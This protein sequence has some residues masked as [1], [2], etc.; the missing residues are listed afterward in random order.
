MS[1]RPRQP[2]RETKQGTARAKPRAAAVLASNADSILYLPDDAPVP[3]ARPEQAEAEAEA[4]VTVDVSGDEVA[5]QTEAIVYLGDD[6]PVP[7]DSPAEVLAASADAILYLPDEVP[8]VPEAPADPRLYLARPT[9]DPSISADDLHYLAEGTHLRLYEKLG[10][11]LLAEGGVQFAVWAPNA[12]HVSVIGEW[13]DWDPF[14]HPL[15]RGG[16]GLWIGRVAEAAVGMLYKYRVIG[17]RGEVLDKADPCALATELPPHTASR[18]ADLEYAWRDDAWLRERA[19]RQG[20]HAPIS[21]YELHLGSWL[22][23][24]EGAWL[25]YREIAA[26]LVAHVRALGFTHVEFMPL[27]EHPFYGSWG[28]QTSGYFAPS[29]R[30]GGPQA[31]M[32]LIDE[33]HRAEIGVI[34]DWVPGHFPG[35]AHGLHRFDGTYLYE[36]RDPSRGVHPDW[37]TLIFNHGRHEVRA[38]LLS[39]ASMWIERYHVDAIRVDAVASMLY[40]DYSRQPGQWQPNAHGG[41]ENLEAVAF[42]RALNQTIH[43]RHPGVITIAE[44]STAWPLVTGP[45]ERGGLGFDLKWDMGWMHDSLR[46]LGR[47]PV[48]RAQHHNELTFRMWY[49]YNERYMLPLSHDEVVHGK[50][51]LIRKMYGDTPAK[52]AGLRLLLGY[53]FSTPGRKL[54]FMGGEFGQVREWSHERELDWELLRSPAHA[55]ALRWLRRVAQLYRADPAL[56]ELDH[57]PAG[58]EWMVVDDRQRSLAVYMRL[59][60][61]G[62]VMLVALNF[63]PVTWTEQ[64]IGVP[65]EGRW[66]LIDRSDAAAYSGDEQ[67]AIVSL[68]DSFEAEPE[69]AHDRPFSLRITLPPLTCLLLRGPEAGELRVAAERHRAERIARETAAAAEDLAR[70]AEAAEATAEAAREAAEAAARVARVAA[71]IASELAGE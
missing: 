32:Y 41:R 67:T 44:E 4:A 57:D 59:P 68:A 14:R 37:N 27:T 54:L 39:S 15:A 64:R 48:T 19:A 60:S 62:P 29:A 8:E 3:K 2:S 21:V 25:G 40:L 5:V 10:A 13:N 47:D 34:L 38:F 7:K 26:K 70:E 58:F 17:M 43:A 63:T 65:A 30:Y 18:I 71:A 23:G 33:L 12:R 52:F 24:P 61:R 36:H 46:Y 66:T 31:L 9:Q 28:Y 35:D 22:R 49:A 11:Q 55:G 16:G 50:G 6:V 20:R 56:H 42:L 51:S 1:K 53:M 69:P 45:V